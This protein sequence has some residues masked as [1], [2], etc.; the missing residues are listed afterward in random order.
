MYNTGFFG[1][2]VGSQNLKMYSDYITTYIKTY[3]YYT[4]VD[5]REYIKMNFTR[6]INKH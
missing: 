1:F 5:F 4:K 2:G 3:I 6:V